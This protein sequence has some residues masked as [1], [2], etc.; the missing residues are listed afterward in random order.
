[1]PFRAAGIRVF[2][3]SNLNSSR[4]LPAFSKAKDSNKYLPCLL[5]PD[6]LKSLPYQGYPICYVFLHPAPV[7]G[8]KQ[9]R[10]WLQRIQ[11]SNSANAGSM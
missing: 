9:G 1:M 7:A 6:P 2:S 8:N 4:S 10:H 5:R 3:S 11:V